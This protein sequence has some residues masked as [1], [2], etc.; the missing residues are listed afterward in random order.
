MLLHHFFH[1]S[2]KLL[3]LPNMGLEPPELADLWSYTAC[4]PHAIMGLFSAS[5]KKGN[6]SNEK[7][8]LG[9]RGNLLW[10]ITREGGKVCIIF[11]ISFICLIETVSL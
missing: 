11:T 3:A 4:H 5:C 8:T 6:I 1:L 2:W 9:D 10:E 7:S